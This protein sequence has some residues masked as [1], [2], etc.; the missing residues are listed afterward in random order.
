MARGPIVYWK[1]N[2]GAGATPPAD[3]KEWVSIIASVSPILLV[4]LVSR[5]DGSWWVGKANE[6]PPQLGGGPYQ[7]PLTKD[8]RREVTEALR[9]ARKPVVD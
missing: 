5:E 1:T 2:E 8:R 3:T 4:E 9:R 6:T 7:E